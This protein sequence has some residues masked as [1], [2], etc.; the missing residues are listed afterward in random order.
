MGMGHVGLV[1]LDWRPVPH[2]RE[3]IFSLF[4]S[5]K[6]LFPQTIMVV[7]TIVVLV[8]LKLLILFELLRIYTIH[9]KTIIQLK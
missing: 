5:R 3:S 6:N 9:R 8:L 2:R 4:H 7:A 1:I